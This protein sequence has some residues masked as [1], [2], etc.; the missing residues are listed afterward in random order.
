MTTHAET[1]TARVPLSRE[2]VLEAAVAL[3]D[4]HGIDAVSMRRV[5]QE[6]GVEAMSL[7]NHVANKDDLLDGMVENVV[8]EID[9]VAGEPGEWR[10]RMRN[11]ALTA[12]AVM[13]RHPWAIRVLETRTTMTAPLLVYFDAI[14]GILLDAG[15]SMELT[16]HAVHA[17]GSRVLGFVQ[18]LFDDSD[19]LADSPEVVELMI[20]QMSDE[21]P[22]L[23]RLMREIQH[24]ED[25]IL[26]Q[27]C[28]DQIEFEF[29]LDVILD[30][31][32][33]LR[34]AQ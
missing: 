28:D 19:E 8:R 30:G 7:Y 11:Q 32:E 29:G 33:R 9:I 18:E 25:S 23:A 21:Y 16:H 6:L 22:N 34:A 20:R 1:S 27:G 2:R 3:A 12:R 10:H 26:G 13:V 14:L 5:G 15:F 17:L 24:D 4:E 31:L